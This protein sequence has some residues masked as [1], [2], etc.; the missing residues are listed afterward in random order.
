MSKGDPSDT[1]ELLQL[2]QS[3]TVIHR[4]RSSLA[5]RQL[6]KLDPYPAFAPGLEMQFISLFPTWLLSRCEATE[7]VQPSSSPQGA[8]C[9]LEGKSTDV[10]SL[11][12]TEAKK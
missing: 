6:G 7:A 10:K 1:D 4:G 8:Q 11:A 9:T 2:L 12:E 3:L 5:G